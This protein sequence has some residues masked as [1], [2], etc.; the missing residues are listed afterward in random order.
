MAQ[1]MS[2]DLFRSYVTIAN[3]MRRR[4]NKPPITFQ[5]TSQQSLDRA[6]NTAGR[7]LIAHFLVDAHE[8]AGQC[9][10]VAQIAPLGPGAL[11]VTE[12]WGPVNTYD[13]MQPMFVKIIN[14]QRQNSQVLSAETAATMEGI[15]QQGIRNQ[16]QTNAI[17]A[18]SDA[19]AASYESQRQ[20]FNTRNNVGGT[21]QAN[22][23]SQATGNSHFDDINAGSEDMQNY[24]LD[25]GVV[26]STSTGN[27]A[28]FSDNFAD[29]LVKN[30]PNKLQ[31]VTNRQLLA[32]GEW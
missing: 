7:G 8:G 28:T 29:D 30:N 15:R 13:A 27:Y 4:A 18:R 9:K 21:T 1:A 24:I 12:T 16:N 23:N 2:S 31:T 19:S 32:N 22:A 25:R 10:G 26:Q 5:L 6:P 14:T 17:N 3:L 20:A 11:S